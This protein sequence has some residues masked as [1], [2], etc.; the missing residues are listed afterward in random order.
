MRRI[1]KLKKK[2]K[3]KK[4]VTC[5]YCDCFW[6]S[7]SRAEGKGKAATIYRKCRRKG[8]EVTGDT[9]ACEEF[10]ISDNIH[11]EKFSNRMAHICCLARRKYHYG[12]VFCVKKCPQVA[13][14]KSSYVAMG[15]PVPEPRRPDI[16]RISARASQPRAPYVPTQTES[17]RR[18]LKRRKR[19]SNP[20]AT[21][22]K[23]TRRTS[24]PSTPVRKKLKRRK[25]SV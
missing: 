10:A 18:R 21:V 11:C 8:E 12:D 1:R 6:S 3:S 15:Q 24:A 20:I 25:R 5:R 22:K 7:P 16:S 17:R 13:I 2:V 14:I 19:E 23:L 9:P 4:S